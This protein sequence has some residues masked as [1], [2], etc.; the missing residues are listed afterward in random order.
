MSQQSIS[1]QAGRQIR[2]FADL[3]YQDETWASYVDRLARRFKIDRFSLMKQLVP[4]WNKQTHDFD[5]SV[6]DEIHF[7]LKKALGVSDSDLPKRGRGVT[8]DS[9]RPHRRIDYCPLCFLEDLERR[10]TP[11]F[12][13]QWCIPL[14]TC[15]SVHRTPLVRWRS[16]R[17]IDERILP[18]RWVLHPSSEVASD[19]PWLDADARRAGEGVL[20]GLDKGKPLELVDRLSRSLVTT[21]PEPQR[22]K[23]NWNQHSGWFLQDIL[24]LG[25]SVGSSF[26]P[27]AAQL[28]P[29]SPGR[30]FDGPT[31]T[32][33]HKIDHVN[34]CWSSSFATIEF[35]RSLIWFA[36]RTV[37]SCEGNTLLEDG[38]LVPAGGFEIWW[39]D[40]VKPSVH[41]KLVHRMTL[42]ENLF[43]RRLHAI[44]SR[45]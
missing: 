14:L 7:A 32:Y 26:W 39:E 28:R 16:L 5:L 8:R 17:A 35:R 44:F 15:C 9:L 11:Y 25:A 10:K 45:A 12:R 1:L 2:I 24:M 33:S 38:R 22:W 4:E 21:T 19:C 3:P 43:R 31:Y 29:Q 27:I 37:L 30:F 41:T 34:R 36:A 40:F 6:P 23:I 42:V 13:Y 18:L 20:D